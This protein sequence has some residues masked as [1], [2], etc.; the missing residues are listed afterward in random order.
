MLR[1]FALRNRILR[2]R[3]PLR[4]FLLLLRTVSD[5]LPE[6]D[7]LPALDPS[8][9]AT[10]TVAVESRVL[11]HRVRAHVEEDGVPEEEGRRRGRS[12]DDGHGGI[13]SGLFGGRDAA[14]ASVAVAD[15]PAALPALDRRG[16]Q[17]VAGGLVRVEHCGVR[18]PSTWPPFPPSTDGRTE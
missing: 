14:A 7:I 9:V 6:F 8:T 4:E 11:G 1:T 17:E 15:P 18:R 13:E 5:H 3:R 2:C 10:A 16:R 12:G